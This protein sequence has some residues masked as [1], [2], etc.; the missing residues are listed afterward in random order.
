MRPGASVAA[1]DHVRAAPRGFFQPVGTC[2]MGAVVD[3]A[4]RVLGLDDVF[5]VDASIIP[6][7]P[8]ANPNLTVVALAERLAEQLASL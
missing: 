8:R 3:P 6:S 1:E 2:A 7:I 4:G 5:V